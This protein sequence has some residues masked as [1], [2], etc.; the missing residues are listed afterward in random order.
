MVTHDARLSNS[1]V[2]SCKMKLDQDRQL[3]SPWKAY[4]RS[5]AGLKSLLN[6]PILVTLPISDHDINKLP[7]NFYGSRIHQV[8][9]P[10]VIRFF[11]IVLFRESGS[12]R[13]VD[14]EIVTVTFFF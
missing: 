11:E 7:H 2:S 12:S 14:Q 9:S 10:P 8:D 5:L 1:V 13:T 6:I 4:S 3:S